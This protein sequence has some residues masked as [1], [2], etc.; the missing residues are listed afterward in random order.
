[1]G[2]EK[3]I[4]AST[5]TS[6]GT[7][8]GIDGTA[9][10]KSANYT[11][12]DTDRIQTILATTGASNLTFDLPTAADNANRVVILKKVDSG[13]G[14]AIFD[15]EGA[16]T[17]DGRTTYTLHTQYDWVAVQCNATGT[18]WNVI[19]GSSS[20]PWTSF[21]MSITGVTSNPTKG[22]A[23][24]DEARWRRVGDSM[25]ITYNLTQTGAG[26]AGSGGY[27]FAIPLS[28]TID[29]TKL[30]VLTNAVYAIGHA[31][32]YNGT[33]EVIGHVSGYNSTKLC[34]WY[35]STITATALLGSANNSL[36]N[37]S[38][39]IRFFTRV[40]ITEFAHYR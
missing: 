17:I 15:G 2:R 20:T 30:S 21:T 37:A 39:A 6:A 27:L 4:Q 8:T 25:E 10:A 31:Y 7:V 34:I 28:L 38:Q 24:V 16:E 35:H 29:T 36:A 1:M 32:A 14:T 3:T 26:A 40:P 12:T 33:N 22:T 13:A 11:I 9:T 5:G 19:G 18:A 23:S